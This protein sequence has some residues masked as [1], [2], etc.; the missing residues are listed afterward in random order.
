M[1][2]LNGSRLN[3]GSMPWRIL[4]E[5]HFEFGI[6]SKVVHSFRNIVGLLGNRRFFSS[7]FCEFNQAPNIACQYW[8]QFYLTKSWHSFSRTEDIGEVIPATKFNFSQ[9]YAGTIPP[10]LLFG[11]PFYQAKEPSF[12]Q[13]MNV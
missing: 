13:S 8:E 2:L 7:A 5:F 12:V 9:Y 10:F 4:W 1:L 6:L 3:S 11:E